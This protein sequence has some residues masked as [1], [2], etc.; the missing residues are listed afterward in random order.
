ML[1][2]LLSGEVLT[3]LYTI[4]YLT[5]IGVIISLIYG[6]SEWFS[7]DRVIKLFEGK[8][9]FVFLGNE[10]YY[11]KIKI[12][13]RSGGSFEVL[14]PPERIE[15]PEALLAY[16]IENYKETGDRK[17]LE[18]AKRLLAD[19]KRRNIL[20]PDYALEKV[21]INPWAPPS[22]VSRKIYANELGNLHALII[23]RDFLEEEDFRERWKELKRVFHPSF[24]GR[25]KR[26]IYNSLAYVKDKLSSTISKTTGAY[27]SAFSPEI[28]K[29]I[30]EIETKLITGVGSVYDPLL[31]NSIGRI[32]TVQVQD[33]DGEVKLYQGIL[34]EYSNNFIAIYDVGYRIQLVTRFKGSKEMNGF[35]RPIL[36]FHGWVFEV[37]RHIEIRNMS[38]KEG[39]LSFDLV[40]VSKN[41]LRI[42]KI[43]IGGNELSFYR[44]LF[45]NESI[46]VKTS[47]ETPEPVME[48]SYEIS[49]EAD[50]IWPR[51]K[52]K[53]VGLGDYP[54][55][56]LSEILKLKKVKI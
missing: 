28:R 2:L 40:N 22:L 25:L 52:V 33:V 24:F 34:R 46:S 18:E 10:A 6:I 8:H 31:E 51:T 37:G 5:L 16:L 49:K 26:K 32:I 36:S 17:F 48:I 11:G 19:F 44:V 56:L 47:S 23:F 29:S 27:L 4:F 3:L 53:V 15:N 35:P 13:A 38:F 45:P 30:Q 7:R 20:P 43:K 42:E 54:P 39:Q 12:P 41:P 14:F 1:E 50:I 55:R 21:V 9:A